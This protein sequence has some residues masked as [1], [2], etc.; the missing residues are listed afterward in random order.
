MPLKLERQLRQLIHLHLCSAAVQLGLAGANP[1]CT[2]AHMAHST[3]ELACGGWMPVTVRNM[4]S[5]DNFTRPEEQGKSSSCVDA[6]RNGVTGARACARQ[7]RGCQRCHPCTHATGRGVQTR[8]CVQPS[9]TAGPDARRWA[10]QRCNCRSR[11]ALVGL[12]PPACARDKHGVGGVQRAP[13][14]CAQPVDAYCCAH[15]PP[16]GVPRAPERHAR[17]CDACLDELDAASK[18]LVL[19]QRLALLVAQPLGQR[20]PARHIVHLQ[21][22][23]D[24]RQAARSGA[25]KRVAARTAAGGTHLD[26]VWRGHLQ[27]H[28]G[29]SPARAR[30]P[31]RTRGRARPQ[32]RRRKSALIDDGRV[33]SDVA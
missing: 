25:V 4:P 10:R 33:S 23:S 19:A 2:C 1:R 6:H 15:A 11:R 28:G 32:R 26:A 21:G 3:A 24:A 27:R 18:L 14:W 30:A 20:A 22:R 5:E 8:G 17:V 29:A 31:P 12:Q 16:D 13:H 9:A 7:C